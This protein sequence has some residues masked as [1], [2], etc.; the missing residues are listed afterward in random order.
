MIRSLL[1][2]FLLGAQGSYTLAQFGPYDSFNYQAVARDANGDPLVN[3]SISLRLTI[4]YGISFAYQET[5]AATTN[6]L[7]LFSVKVG[8]GTTTGFGFWT[9]FDEISW[10]D[11]SFWGLI[12][13]MDPTGGTNYQ[14]I[15]SDA[16]TAVPYALN[17]RRSEMLG[18]SAW[19]EQGNVVYNTD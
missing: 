6:E 5:Y 10:G 8:Q 2:A 19:V 9:V 11:A 17:S 1:L 15:G 7:G 12:V 13:E 16:L 18:D 14:G 3:Q 4:S